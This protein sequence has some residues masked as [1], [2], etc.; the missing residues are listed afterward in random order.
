MSSQKRE[1]S[2]PRR[3]PAFWE[4]VVP[5]AVGIIVLAIAVLL[6]IIVAVAL[7]LFPGR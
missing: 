4:K 7:G 5:I 1:P 6:V 3:Y 2:T